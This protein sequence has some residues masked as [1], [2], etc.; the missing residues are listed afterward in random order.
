M[1]YKP[2]PLLYGAYENFCS[3]F[4]LA[5]TMC[6]EVSH[7]ALARSVA[8][9]MVRYPYFSVYPEQDGNYLSLRCNPHPVPVFNDDRCVVLG[10]EE[11]HGHLLTF[12][13]KGRQ[14]FLNCS[15][16]IADG[17]GIDPLLKTVLFLYVSKVYGTDGLHPDGISMPSD[18]VSSEEYEYPFPKEPFHVNAHYLPKRTANGVYELDAEAFDN[19]GFYAYHLHIPQK[20]MMKRANPADGSPVSFFSV[21]LYRALSA[22]DPH[23]D[24]P[25]VVHVQHQYRAALHAPFSRHSLVSYIP[26]SFPAKIKKWNVTYQNTI[27]RG[28]ILLGSEKAADLRA[29]NRLLA[30]LPDGDGVSLAE[31]ERS[32]RQYIEKSIQGK[33]FGISYVGKMDWCGLD[34]YVEDMHAYLGEKNT[35]N[36]LLIEVMT[37]GND[38]SVNFM[39]SGRGDRY[40]NAFV[41][42]LKSFEIPVEI[43]GEKRYALCDTKIPG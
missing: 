28:Q 21:M 34:R 41:E 16:Y 35:P 7:E 33:T 9:A 6:S 5:I 17:M 39:Q 25:T 20:A 27:V 14:I 2:N 8:E 24:Q 12:G 10:S 11:C 3:S 40:V 36:M 18:P 13:C 19:G 31:K 32:M 30:A 15:H 42:Q 4:K 1:N 22:I 38:F 37:I 26:V 23:I 43:V 29:V